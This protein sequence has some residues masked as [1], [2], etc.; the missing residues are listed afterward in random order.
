MNNTMQKSSLLWKSV[1]KQLNEFLARPKITDDILEA[2][3]I[4]MR[5]KVDSGFLREEDYSD[6]V[7]PIVDVLRSDQYYVHMYGNKVVDPKEIEDVRKL[8]ELLEKFHL[9]SVQEE[10]ERFKLRYE[11]DKDPQEEKEERL[12][13]PDESQI[14]SKYGY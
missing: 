1:S 12:P 4:N 6:F 7:R 13:N 5:S 8:G 9:V 11:V 14:K 10:R 3:L 2:Q